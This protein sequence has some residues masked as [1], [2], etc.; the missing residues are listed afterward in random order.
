[1]PA[2]TG[3]RGFL[4]IVD[5]SD[6]TNPQALPPWQYLGDGGPH[7]LKLNSDGFLPGVPE[8]TLAVRGADQQIPL[9]HGRADGL[10]IEDVSDYQFRRP[11]PQIRII[12]TLFWRTKGEPKP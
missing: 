7:S 10:V 3:H 9:H 2:R 11:N 12:S 8:G 6:P 5:V 1:M 4:Y